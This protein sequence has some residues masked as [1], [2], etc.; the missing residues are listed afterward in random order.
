M[1]SLVSAPISQSQ[2]Q[3]AV[4][5]AFGLLAMA[6]LAPLALFGGLQDIIVEGDAGATAANLMTSQFLFRASIVALWIVAVLDIIVA[7]ALYVVL[8]PV[9]P[10]LSLLAA[11]FRVAYGAIFAV[12]FVPLLESI[13]LLNGAQ[14]LEA[15]ST[16]Q[17]NAQV[18]LKLSAFHSN[19]NLGL[20]VFGCH[21]LVLGYLVFR[22]G[23]LPRFLG[24]LI[25]LAGLGYLVD[26]LGS[27]LWVDYSLSVASVTFIGEVLL[28]FWLFRLGF[29]RAV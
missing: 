3:G 15:F 2:R 14:Y 26:A 4:T 5:G 11:W 13:D 10:R 8:E 24:G 17:I 23:F 29:K 6:L 20:A 19:W 18:L 27:I 1:P 12:A 21:L 28:I 7:W 25:V 16:D 9:N 22:S